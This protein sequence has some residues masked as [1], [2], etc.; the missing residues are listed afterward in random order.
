MAYILNLDIGHSKSSTNL[1]ND[2]QRERHQ[3]LRQAP[4]ALQEVCN[5]GGVTK[6]MGGKTVVLKSLSYLSLVIR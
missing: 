2:K 5:K 1:A 4:Q 3:V 6:T